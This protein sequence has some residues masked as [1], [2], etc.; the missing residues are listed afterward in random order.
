MRVFIFL[1]LF[2]SSL[3]LHAQFNLRGFVHDDAGEALPGSIVQI[4][5]TFLGRSCDANGAFLFPNLKAGAY[6][7]KVTHLGFTDVVQEIDLNSDQELAFQLSTR[8]VQAEAF[9][10]IGYRAGTEVPM[11]YHD[12]SKE[13][14]QKR[15]LGVDVP[16]LLDMSPSLYFTSDAG[17][18]IGYTYMRLRGSDQSNINVMINGVPLNDSE[19]QGVYWVDLP[20]LASSAENIQIQRGVGTSVNGAGGFGGSVNVQTQALAAEPYGKISLS[21]GSFNTRRISV[22][23]GSGLLNDHWSLDTRISRISS[24]GYIDRSAASLDSYY[25]AAGYVNG[26]NT[27]RLIGFG[28]HEVTQQAWYG[29]PRA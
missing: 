24:D 14:L 21:G 19:S 8:A 20:D 12:I 22:Q 2:F 27:L 23:A 17:T 10:V 18:G 11:A 6:L 4:E 25:L 13:E 16:A 7:I 28:G 29:V 1:I 15:N 3:A 26:K 5:G 9:T